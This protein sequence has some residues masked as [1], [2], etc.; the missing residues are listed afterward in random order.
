M[1]TPIS[2]QHVLP[3]SP[4]TCFVIPSLFS[5]TACEALLNP[6]IKNSFQKANSNY[7]TYY[8]NND[9][10]VVD[11]EA[12]AEQLFQKVKP[13]LPTTIT[14][15][16]DIPAE[17]GI[18]Q[19]QELNTRLRFCKYSA[20]QYFHRHLDGVHY[21]SETVQSK[22]T[23]M[24]Y[25]NSATEFKG[26]R[27]LFFKTKET[28]EVWASYIPR[29][30]DL[31]VF[32]HNV[33]HE[34]EVLSEG[35]KF[36]LRSDILY[37]RITGTQ[38]KEPFAGHLGYIWSLLKFDEDTIL[39]GG[40]DTSIKAWSL[41]G[42]EKLSL[43]E[44]QHS[45]L[46]LEKMNADTFISGSRDQQIIVWQHYKALKK[47][48]I[49]SAIV[50]SLCR[51][52]DNTFAS[53]SGDN[54]IHIADLNG[55]VLKTITGHTNWVWQVIKLD[56]KTIA[57]A[58]E[59]HTIKIWNFE[60]GQLLTTFI[61]NAPVISVAFHASTNQL[62]SGNLHG[63]ISIRSLN[64]HSC[65]TFKAHNGIIR[66]IKLL[67]NNII[68]TGGEDNKVKLWHFNGQLQ[69]ELNHQNFVQSIEQLA[70]NKIISASYDGMIKVWEIM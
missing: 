18:W 3:D 53:G 54:T 23:F 44:H 52:T 13:Y 14:V 65:T 28:S 6:A 22:L 8:R 4:Y 62:I 67:Q 70:D 46:S 47:I 26:G 10:F 32:D 12:L 29:Q 51:I 59:D 58:S 55:T 11:D 45:I 7:P 57:S 24:I 69:A 43:R 21:R 63:E 31:I 38:P 50:L 5:Q 42:E 9:R 30:G 41:W 19:L 2:V 48:R 61:E 25:L 39:S 20:N 27:T 49:H 37:T 34:G 15:N 35:E 36:V 66:T 56:E 17:N 1:A 60:T 68:A 40:R 33:W 64:D 16:A